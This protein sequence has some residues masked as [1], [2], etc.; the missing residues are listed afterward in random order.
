MTRETRP[1]VIDAKLLCVW[2]GLRAALALSLALDRL[3]KVPMHEEIICVPFEVGAFS[4]FLPGLEDEAGLGQTGRS[5]FSIW[6]VR[7]PRSSDS[8]CRVLSVDS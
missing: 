5:P 4:H 1:S 7:D 3:L 6:K 2:G 8:Q